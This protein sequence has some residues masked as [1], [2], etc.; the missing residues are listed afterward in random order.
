MQEKKHWVIHV[1]SPH[2]INYNPSQNPA[3]IKTHFNTYFAYK[4]KLKKA[5][6]LVALFDLILFIIIGRR[7]DFSSNL[8]VPHGIC[9]ITLT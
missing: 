1:L 8:L 9:V 6:L 3:I 7:P 4:L 5:R 2:K